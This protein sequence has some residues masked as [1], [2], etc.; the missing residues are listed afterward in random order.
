MS[1]IST[2]GLPFGQRLVAPGS[3]LTAAAAMALALGAPALAS[4]T[5]GRRTF[6]GKGPNGL[7]VSLS[8]PYSSTR[9]AHHRVAIRHF[10][11]QVTLRCS[12]GTIFADKRFADDVKV[13]HGGHFRSRFRS[14]RGATVT[15]VTGR[16]VRR[17]AHGTLSITEHYSTTPDA[18]GNFPLDPNGAVT[19]SSGTVHWKARAR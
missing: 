12:D 15:R 14:D 2:A 19:C 8:R 18:Q 1:L 10:R 7:A 11:Y 4:G 13:K 5:G 3:A 6:T 17:R 9:H 16:I